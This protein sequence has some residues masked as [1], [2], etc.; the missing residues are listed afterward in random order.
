MTHCLLLPGASGSFFGFPV[1]NDLSVRLF[2]QGIDIVEVSDDGSGIPRESR[3]LVAVPHATSKIKSYEDIYRD[4]VATTLGFRGEAL[5]CLANIS[6]KLIIATRTRDEELAQKLHFRRDGSLDSSATQE[7]SRKIGTTAAILKLFHHLPVRRKDMIRRIQAQRERLLR[8]LEGQAI[9]SV[10]VCITLMDIVGKVGKERILLSTTSN[11]TK[12]DDTI[13][14]IH[15]SKFLSRL[16][17]FRVDLSG[18]RGSSPEDSEGTQGAESWTVEGL[19]SDAQKPLE[20]GVKDRQYFGLNGRSVDFPA[21]VRVMNEVWRSLGLKRSP[22]CVLNFRVPNSAVD[23]NLSPDKRKIEFSDQIAILEIM[24]ESLTNLWVSQTQ[25]RFQAQESE[26]L[27]A[28]DSVHQ[29]VLS[30]HE[31]KDEPESSPS[32]GRFNR[33]YAFS[34][35]VSQIRLQHQFDD[36]RERSP[37]RPARRVTLSKHQPEKRQRVEPL[38]SPENVTAATNHSPVESHEKSTNEQPFALRVVSDVKDNPRESERRRWQEAKVQFN[39]SVDSLQ[40]KEILPDKGSLVPS[41]APAP[42]ETPRSLLSSLERFGF[43]AEKRISTISASERSDTTEQGLNEVQPGHFEDNDVAETVTPPV[44]QVSEIDRS[45]PTIP[46]A[47]V[48]NNFTGTDA[49]IRAAQEERLNSRRRREAIFSSGTV[50]D[51]SDEEQDDADS[52]GVRDISLK[53]KDFGEMKIIGQ[54]NM[55][56]ILAQSPDN[57]LWILDQHACD[58]KYNFEKLMRETV[59]HEQ[60]LMA[61]IPLDLSPSE[62]MCIL[63]NMDIFEKN[64]FR[65]DYD[66]TKPPRRRLSLTALPHSGAQEGRKAVQFGKEDVSMLCEILSTDEA[67]IGTQQDGGIGT[68]GSGMYGNNAVRRFVSSQESDRS[69]NIIARLPKAIA[70]F[71]SRACRSSIMI[72]KALSSK[73]MENVVR[74]LQEIEQ[75]WTCAHGRPTMRHVASMK[76]ILEEDEKIAAEYIA[77]PTMPCLSQQ[78]E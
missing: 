21:L 13:S 9:F 41:I 65:F 61:P 31:D 72:G 47:V 38:D 24:K 20:M 15:G 58:E 11:S 77:G 45:S 33:R 39:S 67:H 37:K 52:K 56:F 4:G 50:D 44:R 1:S 28:V 6:E 49:V 71:A 25:G 8:V 35:D 60:K 75:P 48:W 18:A 69:D 29:D 2:N 32:P 59:I 55:G 68:D 16:C 46:K 76:Q 42:V 36:G 73:E 51:L 34:H 5:F 22:S 74:R 17:S 62:E 43:K 54:F 30:D 10:G 78:D 66:E 70:M 12:L 23:V 27:A 63:D 53:K 26:P 57:N 19:V 64:G 3:E 14:S 7:F 40:S